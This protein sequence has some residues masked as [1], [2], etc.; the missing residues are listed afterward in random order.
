MRSM[1]SALAA[2]VGATALILTA[3]P[4]TAQS[5][6]G[7]VS[8]AAWE[9]CDPG[10]FCVYEHAN[11][12]GPKRAAFQYRAPDL[13]AFNLNDQ[14]SSVWNRTG[15]TWCTFLDINYGGATWPVGA[16]WKGNSGVYN[17][18]DNI[19]SLRAGTC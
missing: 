14:V 11:G 2:A 19:S 18:N 17:R 3:L 1:K 16:G 7:D 6:A 15:Q 5:G 12:V 10:E 13:R 4:A 9:G 8:I